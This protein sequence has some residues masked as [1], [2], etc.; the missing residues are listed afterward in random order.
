[1]ARTAIVAEELWDGISQQ[2]RPGAA[3]IINDGQI[4][5]V[6]Q[7]GELPSEIHRL[8]CKGCTLL[9]GLI[10]AHVHYSRPMGPA[11][12][13]A[14][15]TTIRDVGND[16]EWI[17]QQRVQHAADPA[18][19]PGI[20]CCGH[21]LDAAPAIW[22]RMGRPHADAAAL[23]ESV[24]EEVARGVDAVKFYAGLNLEMLREGLDEARRHR[25]FTV[26]HLGNVT[27]ED[28]ARAGL[29]DIQHL[30]GCE[31]AWRASSQAEQDALIDVLL[32]H[33]TAVTPTLVVWDRFGRILDHAFDFDIRRRWLHPCHRDLWDHIRWR[34]DPPENRLR[35]QAALPHLKRCLARMQQRGLTIGLGTDTPFPH[36]VPGFS[37]HDEL[38]MYT[39]AGISPVDALRSATSVNARLLGLESRIGRIASGAQADL[40]AVE[41]NPLRRIQDIANVQFVM[42]AG[43]PFRLQELMNLSRAHHDRMPQDAVTLDLLTHRVG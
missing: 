36:L 1:M 23:R 9:P 6:C 14:G 29:H 37:V 10:D 7:T 3:V 38:A 24:R 30:T 21:L 4:E 40:V 27:A 33:K 41:G 8:E 18:L 2:S 32:A 15:V 20:V 13:A 16:L 43:R 22:S 34:T 11:F 17:L 28:A 42:R 39:D 25:A 5:A 19:G 31:P 12:L 26:A 35:F